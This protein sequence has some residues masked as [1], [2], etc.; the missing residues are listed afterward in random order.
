M[1]MVALPRGRQTAIHGPAINVPTYLGTICTLLPRLPAEIIPLKLKRK[2][3]YKSHYMYDS[4]RPELM[5]TALQWLKTNNKLY[6]NI[7]INN[8]WKAEFEENDPDLWQAISGIKVHEANETRTES[9]MNEITEVSETLISQQAGKTNQKLRRP[10]EKEY[11][12]ENKNTLEYLELLCDKEGFI[13]E[14][15]P[16][17]GDCFFRSICLQILHVFGNKENHRNLRH[18]L[19]TYFEKNPKGPNGD[20]A[21]REFV[22][23]RLEELGILK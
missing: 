21:Y 10:I 2:L 6:D 3:A 18:Q 8:D 5:L 1:K 22:A 4:I 11:V 17:D 14:D 15:V 16:G 9:E 12:V 19:V 7:D 23:N 13:I 20:L